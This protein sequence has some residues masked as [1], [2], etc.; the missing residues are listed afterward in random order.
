VLV[1]PLALGGCAAAE[2]ALVGNEAVGFG[3][4]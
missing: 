2:L 1:L 3:W 4:L